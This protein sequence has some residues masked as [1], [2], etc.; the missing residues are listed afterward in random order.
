MEIIE[1]LTKNKNKRELLLYWRFTNYI[2]DG[3]KPIL[4]PSSNKPIGIEL[5]LYKGE[6]I[7]YEET[8]IEKLFN[9]VKK[10]YKR[11]HL[12][13][14]YDMIE[15]SFDDAMRINKLCDDLLWGYCLIDSSVYSKSRYY[16]RRKEIENIKIRYDKSWE[17]FD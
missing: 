14:L 10:E 17:I 5:N 11:F 7:V 13:Y 15:I 8:N 16:K 2:L 12:T 4:I 9:E 3:N 1:R 6:K